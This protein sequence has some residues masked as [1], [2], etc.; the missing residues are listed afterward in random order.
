MSL[1]NKFK[2]GIKLLRQQLSEENG[3]KKLL[4]NILVFA[5]ISSFMTIKRNGYKL[6]FFPTALSVTMFQSSDAWRYEEVFLEQYLK[7]CDVIIDIGA[8]IG[9]VGIKAA[10]LNKSNKVFAIEAHPKIYYYLLKNIELNNLTNI[11]AFNFAVGN[12]NSGSISFTDGISDDINCVNVNSTSGINVEIRTLDSIINQ[13]NIDF[14]KI[15]VE[16]Y[17]L[18]VFRGA[19]NSLLATNCIMFESW[20]NHYNRYGTTSLE[21][22][23]YLRNYGFSI[24][25]WDGINLSLI[26]IKYISNKCENLLAIKNMEEFYTR[27]NNIKA[28]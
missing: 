6:R 28:K 3:W 20:E 23:D 26:D 19:H 24:H 14:M 5:K 8:N 27:I 2:K 7:E 25:S 1:I 4:G 13:A 16:G 15:D 22:H 10:S 11:V 18:E 17:E 21:V 9:N 12:S